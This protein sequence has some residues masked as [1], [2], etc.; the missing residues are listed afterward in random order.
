MS[1]TDNQ[2]SNTILTDNLQRNAKR[3]DNIIDQLGYTDE[4]LDGT[5]R[6][7]PRGIAENYLGKNTKQLE[8]IVDQIEKDEK[9]GNALMGRM[10]SI[11][12][13]FNPILD[14][15]LVALGN[16]TSAVVND[17]TE[18]CKKLMTTTEQLRLYKS[19]TDNHLIDRIFTQLMDMFNEMTRLIDV[20]NTHMKLSDDAYSLY[21]KY[22]GELELKFKNDIKTDISSLDQLRNSYNK[23][24]EMTF[25]MHE[26]L[27]KG[28]EFCNHM[29][30]FIDK[31]TNELKTLLNNH[32]S[33]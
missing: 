21:C 27:N 31:S 23:Y 20:Y 24:K 33:A 2:P 32:E 22:L 29:I 30:Q 18:A 1:S 19:L 25:T 11:L 6:V 14:S 8:E 13:E 9:I 12:M 28:N 7:E 3:L 10:D 17:V 5:V 15:K 16:G 4:K 26:S